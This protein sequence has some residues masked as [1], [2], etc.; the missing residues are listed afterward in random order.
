MTDEIYMTVDS[1]YTTLSNGVL[2]DSKPNADGTRTDHWKMDLPHSPYLVMMAVGEFKKV[3]DAPVNGKE[4][5][6]YVEKEYEPYAKD[7]FGTLKK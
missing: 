2:A 3:T 6:Y 7:I 4:V 1:K 5:S